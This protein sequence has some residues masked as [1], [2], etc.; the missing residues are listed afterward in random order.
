MQKELEIFKLFEVV[1]LLYM[2][3]ELV[4]D[5]E[6]KQYC[7]SNKRQNITSD[8]DY[9]ALRVVSDDN[10]YI[11]DFHPENFVELKEALTDIVE[12]KNTI[13][14]SLNLQH[15][16]SGTTECKFCGEDQVGHIDIPVSINIGNQNKIYPSVSSDDIKTR[17]CKDCVSQ[18][19][20]KLEW[21]EDERRDILLAHEI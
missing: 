14:H 21:I 2:K 5:S 12:G 11:V 4:E 13:N 6:V 15:T 3:I 8:G 19:V 7:F 20:E 16:S 10:K 17:M 1:Y 9:S 18:I